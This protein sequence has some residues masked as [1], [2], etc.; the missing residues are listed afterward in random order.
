[1]HFGLNDNRGK[2][3]CSAVVP[4][5]Y[6]MQQVV[7]IVVWQENETWF[8]YL[9]EYPD[10]W[11]QGASEDELKDHLRD[12]HADLSSGKIPGARRVEDLILS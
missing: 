1:M 5:G 11:T 12:L 2:W 7:K 8:G 10:Y 6:V 9:Q 4:K 3:E